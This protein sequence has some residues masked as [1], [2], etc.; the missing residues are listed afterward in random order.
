MP[1]NALDDPIAAVSGF[2]GQ[3][4]GIKNITEKN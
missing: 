4:N 1:I 3:P 2:V